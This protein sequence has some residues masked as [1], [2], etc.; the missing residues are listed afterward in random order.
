MKKMAKMDKA[1]G[2]SHSNSVL[3]RQ[4]KKVKLSGSL[5]MQ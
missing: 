4:M 3:M 1:M 5:K 2:H